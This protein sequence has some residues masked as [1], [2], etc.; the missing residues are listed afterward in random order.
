RLNLVAEY[1]RDMPKEF[2]D[3]LLDYWRNYC[4]FLH[5]TY[6]Y[7]SLHPD[8][9]HQRTERLGQAC[10]LRPLLLMFDI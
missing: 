7:H 3:I 6:S 5:L 9:N 10:K 2:G 8:Y 4:G 1:I